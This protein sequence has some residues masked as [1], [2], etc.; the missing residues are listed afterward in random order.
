MSAHLIDGSW[1]DPSES[2]SSFSPTNPL[3]GIAIDRTYQ[4]ATRAE[5]MRMASAAQGAARKM[6]GLHPDRMAEF[7]E[8]YASM[9]DDHREEIS[10]IAHEETGLPLE[11]R[12]REIEFKRMTGQLRQ[13]AAGARDV[14]PSSWRNPIIDSG[15]NIRSAFGPLGGAV[16]VIGPNNFP[17]A[18]NA[19]SGSDFASAIAAGN[20]VIAK[21]H[22]AHPG[23]SMALAKVAH[24]AIVDLGLPSGMVQFFNHCHPEDG[25]ELI[26]HSAVS[27]VSFTGSQESGIA[28]KDV[29]DTCG[30]LVYVEMSSVNPVFILPGALVHDGCADV[31]TQWSQ[32]VC[33]GAGQFCTKPGIAFVYGENSLQFRSAMTSAMNA[34]PNGT[35]LTE[36][37]LRGISDGIKAMQEVGAE[38]LCGGEPSKEPGFQFPPTLMGI[39]GDDFEKNAEVLQRE[40]FGPTGLLV[41]VNDL[42][43]AIR[44]GQQ[45]EGQLTATIY[46]GESDQSDFGIIASAIRPKCGRLIRNAMPTGVA[47]VPSMVHGGPYPA[48]GHSGFTAVGM[49]ASIVRFSSLQCWQ[50]MRDEDLPEWLRTI[51]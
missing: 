40:H 31:A 9:L 45:L 28:I 49:P 15:T 30:T 34:L 29:A 19:I 50:G 33:M 4:M 11:T 24:Q 41:E 48:T 14:G 12:L 51:N 46:A 35:L 1:S 26:Q 39:S 42:D 2:A 22:P 13:A 38:L 3:T 23:T 5:I 43:Q 37:V 7:L 25:F 36:Q 18:F 21:G 17:L 10:A 6:S 16:F 27:A 44:I 32:S 47:V 20:P 8:L